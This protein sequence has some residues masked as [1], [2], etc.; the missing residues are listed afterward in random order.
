MLAI[1]TQ[2][3]SLSI[4]LILLFSVGTI[5]LIDT[6]IGNISDF[7][8]DE[9]YTFLSFFLSSLSGEVFFCLL[10][11]SFIIVQSFLLYRLNPYIQ[12]DNK[13]YRI[14]YKTIL[15]IHFFLISLLL[16]VLLS[17]LL[18][19]SYYFG[20]S[21]I[22]VGVGFTTA[23]IMFFFLFKK[24]FI[25]YI[26][27]KNKVVLTFAIGFLLLGITKIIFELGIFI[28]HYNY[29]DYITVATI[30]EFPDYS[31]N[32]ILSFFQDSYWI[33]A[34][35]SFTLVWL[36]TV[37]LIQHYKNQIGHKKFFILTILSLLV[38]VPT[39]IGIY[40]NESDIGNFIDP[41]IFYTFTTFNATIASILFL[42]TFYT[43]IKNIDNKQLQRYLLLIGIGLFL[44]F[45]SDQGNIEQHA[46]PPY[47]FI[48]I[49]F[50]GYASYLI[51]L[52][53]LSSAIVI[54]KDSRLRKEIFHRLKEKFLY[55]A[56]LGE[57]YQKNENQKQVVDKILSSKEYEMSQINTELDSNEVDAI[58]DQI[59][60]ILKNPSENKDVPD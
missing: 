53:L 10:V 42:I 39:P 37:L 35:V 44:Y 28:V 20:M 36:A 33:F 7:Q 47:G 60:E 50:T 32:P 5:I 17:V 19:N 15:I 30:V 46:Y 59:Y 56:S 6:G 38:F 25:W 8:Y 40:F 16:Y 21:K 54:S 41:V 23:S 24:L 51:F 49:I 57:M 27:V 43:L 52:G 26:Q 22:V 3:D 55:D 29:N 11:G 13:S 14:I 45:I 48:S 1:K 31:V 18:T 2:E 34:V 4:L 12:Q 9:K 58:F